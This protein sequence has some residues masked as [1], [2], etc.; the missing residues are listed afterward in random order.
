M[1]AQIVL[2]ASELRPLVERACV[3]TENELETR[4][5]AK[6]IQAFDSWQNCREGTFWQEF[7]KWLFG[8]DIQY[9]KY[10][11][12]EDIHKQ[13]TATGRAH[14]GWDL[15]MVG[16]PFL[17]GEIQALYRALKHPGDYDVLVDADLMARV[18][19]WNGIASHK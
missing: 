18:L 16:K 2:K 8:K 14:V 12:Y 15:F 19:E 9:L 3:N 7:Q 6:A 11:T 13:L 10:R 4:I 1:T 17:H 5:N